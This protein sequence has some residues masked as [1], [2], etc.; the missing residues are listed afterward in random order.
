[1]KMVRR[2]LPLFVSD[3]A[4][5]VTT[6]GDRIALLMLYPFTFLGSFHVAATGAMVLDT[7]S[8]AIYT[9]SL[10]HLSETFQQG[11]PRELVKKVKKT[12]KKTGL[13]AA[14]SKGELGSLADLIPPKAEDK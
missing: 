1:M 14:A 5:T 9:G 3:I 11:G 6:Y 8:T 12:F 2:A 7:A 4:E 13:K 10:P